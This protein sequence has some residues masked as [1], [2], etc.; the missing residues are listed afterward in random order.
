[1][2]GIHW[3]NVRGTGNYLNATGPLGF[4]GSG[5]ITG[6][7]QLEARF[8]PLSSFSFTQEADRLASGA[9]K[10]LRRYRSRQANPSHREQKAGPSEFGDKSSMWRGVGWTEGANA[11]LSGACVIT[12]PPISYFSTREECTVFKI[13]ANF[14][15]AVHISD[16]VC[17]CV[18]VFAC[19]QQTAV[20]A[21]LVHT[22]VPSIVNPPTPHPRKKKCSKH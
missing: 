11:V 5:Q 1:M 8:L 16:C 13:H 7:H 6:I 22:G 9:P 2:A 4:A 20:V 10:R 12:R 15:R 21:V 19:V 3:F 17:V 14:L 18:C